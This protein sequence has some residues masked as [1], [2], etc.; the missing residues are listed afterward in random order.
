MYL[1]Q[2]LNLDWRWRR[3]F[4]TTTEILSVKL[5]LNYKSIKYFF[6]KNL[7][8]VVESGKSGS[9]YDDIVIDADKSVNS[10]M[11]FDSQ[12]S[13]VYVMTERKVQYPS[14]IFVLM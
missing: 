2:A 3:V 1:Y 11:F 10:D 9:E 13:H 5:V 7:Q 6:V 12:K 8:V 4:L 14:V